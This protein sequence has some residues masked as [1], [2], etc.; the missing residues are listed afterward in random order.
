[1]EEIH[2]G[3][4]QEGGLANQ[5]AES[6]G[7]SIDREALNDINEIEVL[8]FLHLL[9]KDPSSARLR[10]F[11]HKRNTRKKKI[12][13][14]KLVGVDVEKI[15]R[16]QQQGRGAYVCIGNSD[17]K[18]DKI[19]NIINV[20]SLFVEWDD[21]PIEWQCTAWQEV[22]LPTP[23]IQVE[24]GGYSIH[25]Y[26]LLTQPLV[27][28]EWELLQRRLIELCG[29]DPACSDVTRVM[30]LPG[31][32]YIGP[33]S[34]P[35]GRT[36]IIS[37]SGKRYDP[38]KILPPESQPAPITTL[39]LEAP[40]LLRREF[41]IRSLEE[42]H[43]ALRCISP[44][45]PNNGQREE[46]RDLA[47]GLLLAVREAGGDDAMALALLEAHSPQVI[48]AAEYLK[49]EPRIIKSN[50]FWWLARQNGWLPAGE[51][52]TQPQ[53][54]FRVNKNGDDGRSS[55]A[56]K[57]Q[58]RRLSPHEVAK[59][60]PTHLGLIRR[61]SRT[62]EVLTDK[63]RL[64][65]NEISRLY[66]GLSSASE[67]WPKEATTDA[68]EVIANG[69]TFDPVRE[70]LKGIATPPLPMEQWQRLD[71]FLLGVDDPI[72]AAFLP[73]YFISAVARTMEPGCDVRQSPVLIGPQW[74]GK[75]ALGRIL[76][77]PDHWVEGVG[78]LDRDAIQR[79][80]MAWAVELAELDGV[81]RR[82]D[83]EKLKAF[84]TE[85]IDTIQLKYDRH[86]GRHPRKFVFW[87]TANRPP[88]SDPT[89]ASRFVCIPLPDCMLPLDWALAN[90]NA[91]WARAM[92]Q[93]N[94]GVQWSRIGEEARQAIERRNSD[95]CEVDPWTEMVE[96]NLN[97]RNDLGC[98]P[99]KV[100][101]LL[102]Q[103]GVEK[104]R[105]TPALAKRVRSIAEQM[106]WQ[107]RRGR[108]KGKVKQGLWPP[109]PVAV[110][111]VQPPCTPTHARLEPSDREAGAAAVHPLHPFPSEKNERR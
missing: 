91:L 32:S 14:R 18:G 43:E 20:P 16:Y 76:F 80:H 51:D 33:D 104:S 28:E 48:D 35:T 25:T 63:G 107:H 40:P 26:W 39:R 30:R 56:T 111:S 34:T 24:T 77:G 96:L 85:Q 49:T 22:G 21:K 15:T 29:S 86:P 47:W 53:S 88:L 11:P 42:V 68:V 83:Q 61:N 23:S 78:S 31:C 103:L 64:S 50:T 62:G 41:P 19:E 7:T 108:R 109:E 27:P 67:T 92:E 12:G 79:A 106:G 97:S 3:R 38:D 6:P 66:I 9:G 93:Y 44:I 71:Q 101:E 37:A 105:H 87:G 72:A 100:T 98:F 73:R 95:F 1:M 60:L 89:G 99:V 110:H 4:S 5:A 54:G 82:S 55:L 58:P 74:R 10:F 59:H 13:A 36:K 102:E 94:A 52:I 90:R 57:E 69:N 75:T 81:T 70:Y 84:L 65:G 46:F 45:K 8:R 17:G 2:D